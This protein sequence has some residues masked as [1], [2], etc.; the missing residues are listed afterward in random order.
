MGSENNK[1]RSEDNDKAQELC[2]NV[3]KNPESIDDDS[4]KDFCLGE[5]RDKLKSDEE[6]EHLDNVCESF[7]QYA[8]FV[9]SNRAGQVARISSL[10]PA[11]LNLL[12][13]SL[14]QGTP[15]WKIRNLAIEEGELRNQF[16]FDS[17][18]RHAGL[19]NSQDER[20]NKVDSNGNKI[21][22]ATDESIG[23]VH[24]V[25]KSASRDWSK[26]GLSERMMAYQPIINGVKKHIPLK[27]GDN[28]KPP[29]ILVP[30]AGL[31][32][33]ALE[34]YSMG[35]E[36]Q[37]NE[38]S[39]HMLL[40]SNFILNGCSS[41]SFAISP[42]I[43]STRNVCRA[44][45]TSRPILV[46]DI[47]PALVILGPDNDNSPC[48]PPDFSMVAGEFVSIYSK[49]EEH[50]KWQGVASCFFLDTAPN[51][52]EYLQVIWNMLEDNGI[53][54]NFGPLLFHWSGPSRRPDDMSHKNYLLKHSDMDERY[55]ESVEM[56]WDD[57]C[58]VLYNI[59]FEIIEQ[60]IG[61]KARYTADLRSFMNSDFRCV[62]VVCRKVMNRSSSPS[63][64]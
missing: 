55:L 43:S 41:E 26:E 24:S 38:F 3:S 2:L 15:E 47:D 52:V 58:E 34:I 10:P 27:K 30:G 50:G 63:M 61:S 46:P 53:F 54:I 16:F 33:L 28:E 17:M 14:L 56:S 6:R 7:R 1:K 8:T 37:G 11:H 42:W 29:R 49:P 19:P 44:A 18:L 35:Y 51:I 25:L 12:P 39:L 22:W 48:I 5:Q 4:L 40:A 36:V 62:Y 32:R 64:K 13:Q 45:D 9:R 20:S 57:I 60:S 59:G 31:G 21:V 23:K